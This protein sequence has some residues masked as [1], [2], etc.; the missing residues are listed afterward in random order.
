MSVMIGEAATFPNY[1]ASAIHCDNL[2]LQEVSFLAL[3]S[4]FTDG[5]RA[6]S[7]IRKGEHDEERPPG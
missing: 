5:L 3:N 6:F 2:G 7:R 4:L 1:R